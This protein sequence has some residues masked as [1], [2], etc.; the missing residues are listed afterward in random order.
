MILCQIKKK[1]RTEIKKQKNVHLS[2]NLEE[3]WVRSVGKTLFSKIINDYNKKMWLVNDCKKI[4]TFKW[5]PKGYTIKSGKAAA[6]II[7]YRV[8]QLTKQVIINILIK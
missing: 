4:D 3:F 2:K 5:S 1:I 8:I 6:L 7:G